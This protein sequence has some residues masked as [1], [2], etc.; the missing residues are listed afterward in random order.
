MAV[1]MQAYTNIYRC[2]FAV[3]HV[4]ANSDQTGREREGESNKS[5]NF[6]DIIIHLI[7]S[8]ALCYKCSSAHRISYPN[9]VRRSVSSYIQLEPMFSVVVIS[10]TYPRII[11][12]QNVIQNLLEHL[13]HHKPILLCQWKEFLCLGQ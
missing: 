6:W 10:K 12:K 2:T 8:Q 1:H 7:M 11:L 3:R 4:M 9:T 13:C 5:I